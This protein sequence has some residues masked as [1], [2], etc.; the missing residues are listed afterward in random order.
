LGGKH[1]LFAQGNP[2]DGLIEESNFDFIT[3]SSLNI[4][5][6]KE[7]RE[8]VI[9]LAPQGGVARRSMM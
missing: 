3:P 1:F 4:N 2:L 9:E 6:E 8:T 5:C 7:I